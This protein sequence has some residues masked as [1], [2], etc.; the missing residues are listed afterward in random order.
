MTIAEAE[1]LIRAEF[2]EWRD[3]YGT[4]DFNLDMPSFHCWL[5]GEKKEL[6]RFKCR[7][8]KWQ[9]VKGWV[10]NSLR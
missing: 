5:S 9:H 1:R 7:G 8:D 4:G 6:L 10:Q 2:N 3:K